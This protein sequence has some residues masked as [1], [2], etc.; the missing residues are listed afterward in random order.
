MKIENKISNSQAFLVIVLLINGVYSLLIPHL[1][2]RRVGA[3]SIFCMILGT[4]MGIIMM[5]MIHR[6]AMKYPDE[7]VIQYLPKLM[8][9]WMGKFFGLIICFFNLFIAAFYL[10]CFAEML[11]AEL[12]P[13]TPRLVLLGMT[14][15]LIWWIVNNG[16]EDIARFSTLLAPLIMVMCVLVILGNIKDMKLVNFLPF[17]QVSEAGGMGFATLT[18]ISLFL[19]LINVMMIYPK[20]L[21]PARLKRVGIWA[22]VIVGGYVIM[23]IFTTLAV[24]GGLEG[25]RV[26]W[27][28]IELARM[29][30]VG[31]FLER[32]EAIFILVWLTIAFINGS[33]HVYCTSVSWQQLFNRQDYKRFNVLVVLAVFSLCALP[34]GM[35]N[36]MMLQYGFSMIGTGIIWALLIILFLA[37][38][39]KDESHEK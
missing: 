38:F 25:G 16:L 1:T 15:L 34:Q 11:V 12:L 29:I 33:F 39:R 2:S 36:V 19:T 31:P 6:I 35:E 9:K 21:E 8:G 18:A 14:L 23:V 17:G 30:R 7:T 24:F 3:D 28:T 20:V 32:V 27:P 13:N 22:V 5:L 26:V 37:S 10:N 4:V